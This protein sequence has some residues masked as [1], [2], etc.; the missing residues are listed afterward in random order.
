MLLI[1]AENCDHLKCSILLLESQ[2]LQSPAT[3]NA[4]ALP[5]KSHVLFTAT[6]VSHTYHSDIASVSSHDVYEE[7]A[8][9]GD[10]LAPLFLLGTR[11]PWLFHTNYLWG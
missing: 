10:I 9:I 11:R 1:L 8:R 3:C 7:M 2:L 6:V 5:G 4:I